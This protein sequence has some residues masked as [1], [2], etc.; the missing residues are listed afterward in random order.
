MKKGW[1]LLIAAIFL[2]NTTTSGAEEY[3][4]KGRVWE[5]G[6]RSP[7]EGANVVIEGT[8]VYAITDK[9]GSFEILG[10]APGKYKIMAVAMGYE[11]GEALDVVFDEKGIADINLYLER[12]EIE[13]KEIVVK[14]E[15]T[16][17]KISKS[18]IPIEEMR[19]I[20]GTAGDPI[21]AI[22]SLPGVATGGDFSGELFIRGGGPNDN[23]IYIDRLPAGYLYHYG[24]QFSVI[25]PGVIKDFT[26]YAG[27]FGAEF[28]DKMGAVIDIYTRDG[29]KDRFGGEIGMSLIEADMLLEGPVKD[30]GSYMIGGRRSYFD[31]LAPAT[32][33]LSGDLEYRAFPKFYDYYSKLSYQPNDKNDMKLS[34]YGAEDSMDLLIPE[35]SDSALNDPESAGRLF[36]RQNFNALG[37][38]WYYDISSDIKSR[39]ILSYGSNNS[40]FGIG[41][42]YYVK[43]LF[44]D[45]NAWEELNFYKEGHQIATGL[46]YGFS[47]V[48]VDLYISQP[49]NSEWEREYDF[50]T[51]KKFRY[52]D[53][54]DAY[55]IGGYFKDR[56]KISEPVSLTAG[57]RYDYS[58]YLKESHLSPRLSLEYKLKPET[59]AYTAWGYYFQQPAG[60]EMVKEIGNPNL[61]YQRAEHYILG[62]E[63]KFPDSWSVKIE[64]YYK[65]LASLV[66]PATSPD[67]YLNRGSGNV[68]G[69]ELLVRKDLTDRFFGW[70][71]LS[72]SKSERRN[73]ITGEEM[74]YSFDVPYIATLIT[75][76]K[77]SKKWEAGFKWR[78]S[79]GLPYTP[80]IGRYQNNTGR[81]RPV[82][83][84]LNS[85]RFPDYHRLDLR[86]DRHFIF[87]SYK[88]SAYL[89]ILNVYNRQNIQAIDYNAD[90][91]KE[92]KIYQLPL[93]PFFGIRA[94]F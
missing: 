69:A 6:E 16:P 19:R 93:F 24:N 10:L 75:S 52:K 25:N 61:K 3:T 65:N 12:T 8:E 50:T 85:D 80:V 13:L 29:R 39:F 83:G 28:G 86:V 63:R 81:W 58:D 33:K 41:K 31:L 57:V 21:R 74:A 92:E 18:V 54:I 38:N 2:F 79:S 47:R 82:Y 72:Y 40:E 91:T 90:Y 45:I 64:G 71:A 88:M 30:K 56:I 78:Y 66:V 94:E 26:L 22:Q 51:A 27:G 77:L 17:E 32:G 35:G 55:G 20:P 48:P 44:E 1:G 89:E 7:V 59:T 23:L 36:N 53:T 9:D 70:L 46:Q 5:M 87:Q 62:L 67:N 42:G 49:P 11:K 60:N 34:I 84:T 68:R 15:R 76:Y 43:V 37:L 4:I 14:A 73:D